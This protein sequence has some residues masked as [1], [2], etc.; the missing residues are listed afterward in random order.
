MYNHECPFEAYITNFGKYNEGEL[1]GEWVKF[2]TTH[3]AI[4]QVLERI[5]IDG[6]RY[7][8]WSIT[9]YDC[10]VD[11]IYNVLGE[12]ESLDEL[13]YLANVIDGMDQWDLERFQ[14]AIDFGEYTNSVQDLI[15]LAQN[16][17]CYDVYPDVENHEDLGRYWVEDA[18]VYDR[19]SLGVFAN[20]ID[21]EA[22]GRD[23]A[24]DE[25]G[26]FTEHG[27]VTNGKDT[28]V[29]HYDG[30]PENIPEEYL[31]MANPKDLEVSHVIENEPPKA[32]SG[33]ER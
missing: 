31:V 13:N 3:E 23:I 5:G 22:F 25:C 30:K 10:H 17:D 7:E 15:N 19:D 9:D 6:M 24:M 12:Y 33:F 14:A 4:Q 20:Y 32:C 18:G 27:Y 28:F 11:N 8:E 2:P 26:N 29:E 16:L 21:Y 1:V